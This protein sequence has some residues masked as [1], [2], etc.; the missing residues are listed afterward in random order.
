MQELYDTV[1]KQKLMPLLRHLDSRSDPEEVVALVVATLEL[2]RLGGIRAEQR[3]V[4]AEIFLR[5]GP[6]IFDQA[7]AFRQEA[8]EAGDGN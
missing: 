8:V 7:I 4:F 5:P 6:T 3:R 1:H 2:A